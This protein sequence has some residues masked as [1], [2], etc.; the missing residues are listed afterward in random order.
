MNGAR[1]PFLLALVGTDHHPFDRLVRWM[2]DWAGD[3]GHLG[4][5]IQHG[6]ARPPR[7]ARAVDYLDAAQVRA[8]LR[9]SG[10]VVCHGGPATITEARACGRLPLVIPRRK[11]LGEHVD[12]HQ[13]AFARRLQ[14]A[15]LVV[16]IE[17]EA[18]LR[19]H[20]LRLRQ[21]PAAYAAAGA[22]APS[23]AVDR[24]SALVGRLLAERA[25]GR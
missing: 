4:C 16:L 20:L 12:D 18:D 14:R 21:D 19:T 7:H 6:T 1:D 24:F 3:H 5:L 22:P 25:V 10:A 2:D 17:D 8:A 15:G 13:V 23:D 11:A 9:A